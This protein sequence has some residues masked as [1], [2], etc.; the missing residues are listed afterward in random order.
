MTFDST[1]NYTSGAGA[2]SSTDPEDKTYRTSK[3]LEEA[4]KRLEHLNVSDFICELAQY[5]TNLGGYS[6]VHTAS[7]KL[8]PEFSSR[9]RH[10]FSGLWRD[11]DLNACE[12]QINTMV[13]SRET[14]EESLD[15]TLQVKVAVKAFRVH[16]DTREA[17]NK[18]GSYTH[19]AVSMQTDF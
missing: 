2:L 4:L 6:D 8:S 1:H 13:T 9:R 7:L 15:N 16:I 11:R 14:H 18:V 3:A 12:Q 19:E 17:F 10:L 5:A